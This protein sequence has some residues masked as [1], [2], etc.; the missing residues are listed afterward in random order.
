MSDDNNKN[1]MNLFDGWAFGKV[2]YILF[3]SGLM[4]V[5]FG[6]FFMAKGAVDSFQ[7]ITIAPIMLFLG[8][9]VVI[10]VALVYRDKRRE[11]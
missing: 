11:K 3:G 6:Y 1:K 5:I 4:L 9:I 2:N 7:S 8:Y 10:P